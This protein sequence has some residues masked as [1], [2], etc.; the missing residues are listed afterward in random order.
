MGAV[1]AKRSS[2]KAFNKYNSALVGNAFTDP[3]T[4][5]FEH[6]ATTVL[7]STQATVTL[8]VSSM[9]A[10]GFKHL[11][12]RMVARTNR[13]SSASDDS[14]IRFNNDTGANYSMHV[15]YG[16]AG[17]AAASYTTN[18][19]YLFMGTLPG[20]TAAANNFAPVILD[21]LDFSSTSKFKT[22]R[23]ING[24]SGTPILN[25]YSGSWR[26]TSPVTSLN[27]SGLS[28]SFVAGS[29]FSVYGSRG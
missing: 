7:T 22:T 2:I 3:Y 19:S 26:S 24:D 14:L 27:I 21:L 15:I 28:G 18:A 10:L 16:Y 4:P 17:S 20:S 13:P 6:I 29:R 25:Y 12:L 11:Q 23:D 5:N 8:D 1:S 9:A